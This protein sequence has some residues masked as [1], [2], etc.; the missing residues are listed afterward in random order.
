M[1]KNYLRSIQIRYQVSTINQVVKDMVN[2]GLVYD[3]ESAYVTNEVMR[4]NGI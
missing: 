3:E 2:R 4:E 1:S